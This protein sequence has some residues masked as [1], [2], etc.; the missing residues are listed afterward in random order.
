ML[1]TGG[2]DSVLGMANYNRPYVP[3]FEPWRGQEVFFSPYP[4][5]HAVGSVQPLLQLVLGLLLGVKRPGRGSTTHT[6]LSPRL[7]M[8]RAIP[9][10]P[11]CP[12]MASYIEALSL[13]ITIDNIEMFLLYS[14]GL[15]LMVRHI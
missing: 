14:V 4:S 11:L 2:R 12:C 7:R 6:Y 8:S 9:L 3:A 10:L 13:Q 1:S 5:R 15:L